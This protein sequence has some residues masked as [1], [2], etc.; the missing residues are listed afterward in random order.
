MNKN[1]DTRLSQ[2]RSKETQ[3]NLRYS[4][5]LIVK[6]S[7]SQIKCWEE[8][9]QIFTF[10]NGNIHFSFNKIALLS[11]SQEIEMFI[12]SKK[13]FIQVFNNLNDLYA[14]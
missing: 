6:Q 14:H 4:S 10:K 1:C 13:K 12:L 3:F 2:I 5:L 11:I 7:Y 8:M 9:I